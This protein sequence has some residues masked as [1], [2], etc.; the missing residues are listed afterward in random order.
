VTEERKADPK[1]ERKKPAR[2]RGLG[3]IYARTHTAGRDPVFWVEY[4]CNGV[5][6]RESSKSTREANAVKL[7]KR[8][9]GEIGSHT[10]AEAAESAAGAEGVAAPADEDGAT[11]QNRTGD[12]VIFSHVLYQLS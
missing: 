2:P 7:L 5:C 6:H 3:R 1:A 4:W 11:P 9:L 12:T 10:E 8:R